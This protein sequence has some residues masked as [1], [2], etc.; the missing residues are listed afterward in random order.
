MLLLCS[1]RLTCFVLVAFFNVQNF[2]L[3]LSVALDSVVFKCPN[4]CVCAMHVL[5]KRANTHSA[6]PQE[7]AERKSGIGVNERMEPFK[8]LVIEST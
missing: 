7:H 8:K 2:H 4:V 1:K 3:N 5:R 6:I